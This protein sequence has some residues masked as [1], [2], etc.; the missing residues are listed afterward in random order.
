MQNTKFCIGLLEKGVDNVREKK[1]DL[2]KPM[3]NA[4]KCIELYKKE[5]VQ[6]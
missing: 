2:Y 3:Q 1:Y 4:T 6:V 5:G